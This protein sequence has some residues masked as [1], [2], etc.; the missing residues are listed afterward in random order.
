MGNEQPPKEIKV[1][2]PKEKRVTLEPM[3]IMFY[4][5]TQGQLRYLSV[6]DDLKKATNELLERLID[7]LNRYDDEEI[8]LRRTLER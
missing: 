5:D 6:E 8:R 2:N 7:Q 4:H 3:W 1:W